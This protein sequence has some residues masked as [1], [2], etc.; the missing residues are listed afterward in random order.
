MLGSDGVSQSWFALVDPAQDTSVYALLLRC[1]QRQ[2][3]ISGELSPVVAAALPH[4]VKLEEHEPLLG[5]WQTQGAGRNWGILFQ[6]P[7]NLDSL[8]LHFKKFLHA[9]LPDGTVAL[10]RFY[11]PRIFRTYLAAAQP[12]EQ[13][14]WFE[15]VERYWVESGT[16]GKFHDFCLHGGRVYDAAAA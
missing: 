4:V 2:C 9:Q 7:L 16:P 3:L 14:P 10:F 15:G 13:A 1:A 6:S 8:R 5:A 11:D 12:E